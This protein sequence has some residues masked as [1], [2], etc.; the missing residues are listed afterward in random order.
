MRDSGFCFFEAV[1]DDTGKEYFIR[2]HGSGISLPSIDRLK[3]LQQSIKNT[4]HEYE[5]IT[6]LVDDHNKER[7]QDECKEVII[8]ENKPI[9]GFIYLAKCLKT[10]HYKIGQS[11]NV[12]A[13]IKQLKTANSSI[14][15]IFSYEVPDISIEKKCHD[16][17]DQYRV[18][19][20]WFEIDQT[21]EELL[22]DY[23][24]ICV[25]RLNNN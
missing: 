17:L 3:E 4:I 23:I 1:K 6:V 24:T 5:K 13:R 9:P 14:E 21:H 12:E 20:E 7:R 8:Y 11:K 18:S 15:L 22:Y 25:S 10:G 2:S 19:R 16:A